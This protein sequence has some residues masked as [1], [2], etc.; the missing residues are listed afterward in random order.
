MSIFKECTNFI[1]IY[2]Y[3]LFILL[4][5]NSMIENVKFL[6]KPLWVISML[7]VEYSSL[8]PTSVLLLTV[9]YAGFK[10]KQQKTT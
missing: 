2:F 1:N 10:K 7:T 9:Q 3:I 4:I 5:F 8:E 6:K